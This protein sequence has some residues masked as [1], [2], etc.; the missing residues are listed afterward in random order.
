MI[1]YYIGTPLSLFI[2]SFIPDFLKLYILSLNFWDSNQHNSLKEILKYIHVT[3]MF[4]AVFEVH[5]TEYY[6]KN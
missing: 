6:F 3:S 4:H 2:G 5:N 1:T